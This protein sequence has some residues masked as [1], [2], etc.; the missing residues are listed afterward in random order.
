MRERKRTEVTP[1]RGRRKA[2]P[3]VGMVYQA[4]CLVTLQMMDDA[5]FD[6]DRYVAD[7]LSRKITPEAKRLV[8]VGLRFRVGPV[9][10]RPNS[11]AALDATH[12]CFGVEAVVYHPEKHHAA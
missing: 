2:V 3:K 6:V 7:R 5:A 10:R 12:V 1:S 9:K 4:G 8:E 11:F